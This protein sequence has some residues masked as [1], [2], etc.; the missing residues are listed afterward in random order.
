M[1]QW[2]ELLPG[3]LFHF[4]IA[5]T[6]ITD[7]YT[8]MF[9]KTQIAYTSYSTI[10]SKPMKLERLSCN[11][12]SLLEGNRYNVTWTLRYGT[13]DQVVKVFWKSLK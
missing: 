5:A 12:S 9:K 4:D 8:R 2:T 11:L 1:F 7:E 13:D 10:P 6:S 3:D